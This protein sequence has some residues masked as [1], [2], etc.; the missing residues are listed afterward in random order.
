VDKKLT[1]LAQSFD[2]YTIAVEKK[3]RD[4]LIEHTN[5]Q[6][7]WTEA[8]VRDLKMALDQTLHSASLQ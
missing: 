5:S 6:K 8:K 4:Y 3:H 2:T 1:S 7:Q